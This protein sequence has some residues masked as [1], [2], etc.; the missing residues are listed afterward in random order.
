MRKLPLKTAGEMV[1][2]K[3]RELCPELLG[4]Y[5]SLTEYVKFFEATYTDVYNDEEGWV[6]AAVEPHGHCAEIHAYAFDR[7]FRDKKPFFHEVIDDL[8][9][10][11]K[12]RLWTTLMPQ[13]G[14][15]VRQE[16]EALG[17]Q[18]EGILRAFYYTGPGKR[19]ADGELWARISLDTE[20]VD[21]KQN[22]AS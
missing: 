9:S 10:R 19:F 16:L 17:F 7:D 6:L 21:G 4:D 3:F 12:V 13:A 11:G 5:V 8:T 15:R 1:F 18:C 2:E 20:A 22:Q 14:H